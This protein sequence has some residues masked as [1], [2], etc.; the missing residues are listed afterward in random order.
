MLSKGT[1]LGELYDIGYDKPETHVIR[2]SDTL[3]YAFYSPEWNG[4]IEL[5]GLDKGE[6]K[7]Y[8]YVNGTDIGEINSDSPFLTVSFRQYLLIE[9]CKTQ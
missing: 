8:D 1:Y 7:I 4:E 9:A 3:F 2:K 5:R 6:Y